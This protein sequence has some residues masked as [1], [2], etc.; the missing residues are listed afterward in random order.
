VLRV[1]AT[2]LD[3]NI[4]RDILAQETELR[5]Q[6]QKNVDT[7]MKKFESTSKEIADLKSENSDLRRRIDLLNS[8]CNQGCQ[9]PGPSGAHVS[10][11]GDTSNSVSDLKTQVRYLTLSLLDL[12]KQS[13]VL[14]ETLQKNIKDVSDYVNSTFKSLIDL[15]KQ[16]SV[17][18]DTLQENFRDVSAY[19]NSTFTD[20]KLSLLDLQKQS[21]VLNDSVQENFRNV[22]G[23]VNSAFKDVMVEILDVKDEQ[24]KIKSSLS[25]V[26]SS[27]QQA[28]SALRGKHYL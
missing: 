25:S 3:S 6:L 7:F 19:V 8:S 14:N 27:H 2:P 18:N 5:I 22:S 10:V 13:S 1:S 9:N 15:K 17:L 4:I 21:S 26:D 28:T 23:N 11:A 12:Q 20:V 24:N 16:S